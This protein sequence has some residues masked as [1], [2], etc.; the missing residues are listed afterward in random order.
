MDFKWLPNALTIARCLMAFVVGWA[1]LALPPSW[2]F[3]L[4]VI[5]ALSDF[6]DGYGARRLNAVS[7]FGAF[8]DPVA[9]KLLVAVSLI[10]LCMH[11]E[12]D[13]LILI[14]T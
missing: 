13:A 4:F 2:A 9:D 7:E 5:T 3:G 11:Y 6:V 1:I 14:P 12:W 8:L 10:A